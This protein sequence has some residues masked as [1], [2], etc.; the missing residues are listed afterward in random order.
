[1]IDQEILKQS[2]IDFKQNPV[3]GNVTWEDCTS[4][5]RGDKERVPTTFS[6]TIGGLK[7]VI[8]CAHIDLKDKWLAKCHYLDI[9]AH[10]KSAETANEAA[11][12]AIVYC[13]QEVYRIHKAFSEVVLIK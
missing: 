3:T 11:L 13:R 10:L 12:F 1:M 9:H 2:C 6:T 5:S 8:T 7:I 4:Y